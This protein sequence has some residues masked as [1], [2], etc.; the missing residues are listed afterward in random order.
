MQLQ[1]RLTLWAS[2]CQGELAVRA[3]GK[4]SQGLSVSARQVAAIVVAI[5][6]HLVLLVALLRPGAKQPEA[7]LAAAG[8]ASSKLDVR[9]ISPPA[10]AT[11]L[12]TQKAKQPGRPSPSREVEKKKAGLLTIA[13]NFRASAI[14]RPVESVVPER[15]NAA[16]ESAAP[17]GFERR[18][19]IPEF[20]GDGGFRDRLLNAQHSQGSKG[21]P[22][23]D[24]PISPGIQLTDPMNQGVGAVMRDTQRLFGITNR[25][26][27]DVE[28]WQ[29]LSADEL[30][31]RHLS[32]ADVRREGE[33]YNCNR[34][35]GLNF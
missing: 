33:K 5:S 31:A 32:P 28:V 18:R 20:S 30:S 23:S 7:A 34:P 27:I 35:L 17:S 10:R 2:V 19:A 24:T 22:G 14:D 1:S 8:A 9:L 21:I 15:A 4:T 13:R 29:S 3:V 25:H 11:A 12:P 6:F 26:C 16:V